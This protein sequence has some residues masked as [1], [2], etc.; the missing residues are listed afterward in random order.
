M[1]ALLDSFLANQKGG[2]TLPSSQNISGSGSSL[3]QSF[4]RNASQ[5]L[6]QRVQ[7]TKPISS[8][9]VAPISQPQTSFLQKAQ[10]TGK[11]VLSGLG[12]FTKGVESKVLGL[13]TPK[14]GAST[15]ITLPK[16]EVNLPELS[17]DQ[18][19]SIASLN[20]GDKI[21]GF[22]LSS[23]KAIS[24]SSKLKDAGNVIDN[25]FTKPAKF[26]SSGANFIGEEIKKVASDIYNNPIEKL[27][28]GGGYL[29]TIKKNN[30]EI[31][32]KFEDQPLYKAEEST[33]QGVVQGALR[34][35][36][37]WNPKVESFLNKELESTGTKSDVEIVGNT[38]GNI[39]GNIGS[40]ILGGEIATA[41][42]YG[43]GTLP[44]VFATLGQTSLPSDT[45]KAARIRNLIVD[46][47]AGTLLE[48][49]KPLQNLQKLGKFEKGV[50]Y[51]KQLGKSLAVMS[52]Q[53]YL[54]ARSVGAD[55]KQALEMVKDSALLMLGLH[56]FMVA[57][58][59]TKGL[60]NS[61][62]KEGTIIF[63]PDQARGAVVGS[64]LEG[65]Q[66]GNQIMK[67]SLEAEAQGKSL[68]IDLAAAQKSKIASKLNLKT[69]NGIAVTNI[70]FV[71]A[72]QTPKVAAAE[73]APKEKQPIPKELTNLSK[74]ASKYSNAK[75]FAGIQGTSSDR[76]ISVL[77]PKDIVVRDP[78]DKTSAEYKSLLADVKK[79]GIKEPVIVQVKP[80]GKIET[81]EGS[82]RVTVALEAGIKVPVISTK[83]E[84]P[85]GVSIDEFYNQSKS[86]AETKVI[87]KEISVPE[88]FKSDLEKEAFSKITKDPVKVISEYEKSFENEV[89]PDLALTMLKGYEGSNAGELSRAGGVIKN[90]VY[91][92]LLKTQKGVTN[93]TVLITA[94]GS[95]SGKTTGVQSETPL[96]EKYPIVLDTTFSNNSAL[97]EIKKAL[98][99]D[100]D[101]DIA[102]TFRDPADAWEDG[103][104][105]RVNEEGRVVPEA[106]FLQSHIDAQ[107]NIVK[108]YNKYK[109]NEKVSFTFVENVPGGAF[110]DTTFDKIAEHLYDKGELARKITKATNKEYE[111]NRIT[112]K[113]YDAIT[114]DREKLGAGYSQERSVSPSKEVPTE[115]RTPEEQARESIVKQE[116][117]SAWNPSRISKSG[118]LGFN[119]KKL[120]TPH[121]PEAKEELKKIIKQS[122]IAK[123]LSEKLGVP[124]R[125][126][127][128]RHGSAI[129]I[130]KPGSKVV[131]IKKGGL[132]T[133]FH[134]VAHYLD[135]TIGFS[136]DIP[137]AEMDKL[138]QEYGDPLKNLDTR[139]KE[140]FAEY[141]RF[142][143]T[144]QSEK[145]A[146]WAPEFDVLFAKRI[147][148]LPQ[149]KDVID[150][151]TEDFKRWSE[152]PAT[153]K[154]LSQ[155]SIGGQ[156]DGPFKDRVIKSLH[157]VYTSVLDD[158]H[159]LS[160]F[161]KLANKNLGKVDALNDPYILARNLRGWVGKADLFLNQGTF[162]KEFWAKGENGKVKMN[163][164]GK[165]YSEILKP[166]EEMNAM[167]DFRVFIVSQRIVNDLAPR[168]IES[169]ISLEDAK[170][171]ISELNKK[172]PEFEQIAKERREFKN[173]LLDFAKEN[174]VIG[175]EGLKK[176]RE[177]NKYHVPFYRV[178]EESGA[179]F[180]GKSK[181][182]G[183]IGNPI[184]KI[185]GSE[186][187]IIDPLESDVKDV[188]AI[189]NASERNNIGVALANISK[190][191]FE[192]GRLFEEVSKPMKAT[193]VNVKE[194]LE[195]ATKGTDAENIEIPDE[196]AEAVVTLFR[197]TYATGPNMLNVNL[198]DKQK[199]FQVDPDLFKAIQGLEVEDV[200][201]VMKLLSAPAKLLRAG[202]TLSPDFSV[203]NP[204]RDQFTAFV[205]SKYGFIPGVDLV[206]GMF[207][208]FTKGDVYKLWK[209]GGGEHAMFVSLDR[210][211]LQKN[212]KEITSNSKLRDSI[213]DVAKNPL[214]ILQVLSEIGEMGTRLGEM[215]NAL[216][217]GANPI[218]AA[219]ASRN[220]TLDFSR[221]GTK[222]RAINAIVAFFNANIQGTDTMVRKFKEHPFRTLWKTLL[223]LTLPSVLLYLANREDPRWKEIPQWQKNLFWIVMTDKHVWR[224]PKPFELGVLFG[225]VPERIM[226]VIDT[227]DPEKFN[228]LTGA[229]SSG[230]TPGFLP[231]VLIPII[232]N[233]TNYSFFSD[234]P[235]VSR[236]KEGLPKEQQYGP[237]TT[238]VSKI[239]GEALNYSPAKIDNLVAGYG[240]G[241][242]KYAVEGLDKILIG[243]GISNPAPKPAKTFEELAVLKAFLIKEPVGTSSESVN[244]VYNKY[245]QA[246]SELTYIKQLIK[247]GNEEEAVVY[248]KE[249]PTSINAII[250]GGAVDTFSTL[251][252]SIDLIRKAE[253][254]EAKEKTDK[255]LQIQRLQTEI[256]QK[257]LEQIK[258]ND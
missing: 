210:T 135:D 90:L 253:K 109:N 104:L 117:K 226:E 69:P 156:A 56:G 245:S 52:G 248:A 236:G 215:R 201:I 50:E 150:I 8:P 144:N 118:N 182:G 155:I 120:E 18:I 152:Q 129:G 200:G 188:Y 45:P 243:T 123:A 111:E 24:E 124:I 121:S 216:A 146:D 71:D 85:G 119:P 148:E 234:R 54:D 33:I 58:K 39:I 103:A 28:P 173:R 221:I 21:P 223:G 22:D 41:L 116:Q 12:E 13:F 126:G 3:L 192:L 108:A 231:T 247:E 84:I 205:Y 46:T 257:A 227:K 47:V 220:I 77:D 34:V 43:K 183:N 163:F 101:V 249:H 98:K 55:N 145:V 232:E 131:R 142:K 193:T 230:F 128:F 87:Q 209:A 252:K 212:L 97:K 138:V 147:E 250:L 2:S 32:K 140:A 7:E 208:L 136:K 36:A 86:E 102:F 31:Y 195:K 26:L 191:N 166:V 4:Q 165:S 59:A 229:I 73:A 180:L 239:L 161:S 184:K 211:D 204:L 19:K 233:I 160:E 258:K 1:G 158:L 207:E 222:T 202:A 15:P 203:R 213:V 179:K 256:A 241:I 113:Q 64:N 92:D 167:D 68:K 130:Y 5:P 95:G 75:D 25:I 78:V 10:Q 72:N 17:Q 137:D 228:E 38:V 190:Q 219:Y 169:G 171:A 198:G 82:H 154:I 141:M 16:M 74:E 42:K 246:N 107:K 181:I 88:T 81:T 14:D 44:I 164:N 175:P 177:L 240:G 134:E 40:Y 199:V 83:G 23:P 151:A 35:Y 6:P 143:M 65:T 237:Y 186:R 162:S 139:R 157:E 238:E 254:M 114:Q 217:R 224:I 37:N 159:P 100:Y 189:I 91:D 94:G 122:E 9:S 225:S 105:K 172:Y 20:V 27:T 176:I 178:M 66:A 110:K 244:Q 133:I 93:N 61:K 149:I 67:A 62:F 89:S 11:S 194:V 48:Y 242:G 80:D 206:R 70:E 255:I 170:T 125:R 153:S 29:N 197:T 132:N 251:N 196:L 76:Q 115:I 235:I 63:T 187:E 185:K 60:V 214:K 112:K 174:G 96:K 49:I 30:P 218:E 127:K 168:K 99:N 106:Y 51:T 53:V 79:N 57:G